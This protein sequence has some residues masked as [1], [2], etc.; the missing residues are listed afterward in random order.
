M[1]SASIGDFSKRQVCTKGFLTQTLL[2]V[3]VALLISATIGCQTTKTTISVEYHTPK[4]HSIG[5]GKVALVI[6]DGIIR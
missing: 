2:F 4:V 1:S 6:T 3:L 5:E